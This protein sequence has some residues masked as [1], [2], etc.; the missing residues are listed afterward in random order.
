MLISLAL[1]RYEFVSLAQRGTRAQ[2]GL[3]R[4]FP[5]RHTVL[6]CAVCGPAGLLS[7]LL[8]SALCNARGA[9]AQQDPQDRAPV[10]AH[11]AA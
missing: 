5:V 9:V 7:H 6:L 3:E 8:T 10:T 2:A 11:G 1:K 4:G